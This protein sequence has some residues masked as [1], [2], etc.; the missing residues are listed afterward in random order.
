MAGYLPGFSGSQM[1][2]DNSTP[3]HIGVRI[4]Y[5]LRICPNKDDK[6]L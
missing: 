4:S 2:D 1:S 3:S 6:Q 5:I